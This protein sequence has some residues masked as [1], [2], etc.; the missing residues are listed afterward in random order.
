VLTALALLIGCKDE[1]APPT[2]GFVEVRTGGVANVDVYLDGELVGV[3]L[4]RLGPFEAGTYR[5][6][7][8]RFGFDVDPA[9]GI[10]VTVSPG[11]TAIATFALVA[12]DFGSVRIRAFDEVLDTEV[13]GAPILQK[14]GSGDYVSTGRVTGQLVEEI[15]VGPATFLIREVGYEDSAPVVV[16]VANDIVV[17]EDV[18]LAPPHAVLGEMFTF[19]QCT[20][21]PASA[22]RLRELYH[23]NPGRMYVIEW[24]S[25]PGQGLY[26]P[27]W[28]ERERFYEELHLGG[29]SITAYPTALF[30][31]VPPLLLNS[32]PATLNQYDALVADRL[33]DCATDCAVAMKV[34]GPITEPATTITVHLKWRGGALP[35]D[36]KLRF[37]ILVGGIPGGPEG[38]VFHF[39]PRNYEEQ[40]VTFGAPGEIRHFSATLDLNPWPT[41]NTFDYVVYLQSDQT[42]EILAVSGTY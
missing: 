22:D 20:G 38:H 24:H 11:R 15:P 12:R 39:V 16:T 32:L 26:D 23:A 34:E 8:A 29:A 3:D 42:G 9:D 4:D 21:C 36:L 28:Q 33:D 40:D 41:S 10:D 18:V 6:R 5:V 1:L 17:E 37:V 19:V 27:R 14:T 2:L 35:G 30:Q 13:L 31:G 7:V 25:V